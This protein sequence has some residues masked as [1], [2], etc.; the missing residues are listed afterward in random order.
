MQR[1]E[2]LSAILLVSAQADALAAF[3][4]DALGMPLAPAEG[5]GRWTCALG[6]LHFAIHPSTDFEEAPELGTGNVRLGLSVQDLDAMAA[7]LEGRGIE[8]LYT[9]KDL[10]WGKMTAVRDP[11]G[12]Y[13]E[14]TELGDD[15]YRHL[16]KDAGKLS[17]RRPVRLQ[18]LDE[19]P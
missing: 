8:L 15:W 11:D 2:H 18:A 12:N 5:G 17:W 9:P 7:S 3:Y 10:G 19:D 13:V 16:E 1:V 6:E 14:L 4:R